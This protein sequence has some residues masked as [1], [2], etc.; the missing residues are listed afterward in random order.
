[1]SPSRL[2]VG[3]LAAALVTGSSARAIDCGTAAR[4][5]AAATTP[6]AV[7]RVAGDG[8]PRDYSVLFAGDG[9]KTTSDDGPD[10]VQSDLEKYAIAVQDLAEG[11]RN[12]RPFG[13]VQK[14]SFYRI[15]VID[16]SGD[17][18]ND[19]ENLTTDPLDEVKL[20]LSGNPLVP[21]G[22]PIACDLGSRLC[23][24]PIDRLRGNTRVLYTDQ[25]YGAL[26][27]TAF[28]PLPAG[29]IDAVVIVADTRRRA[30]AARVF[31]DAGETPVLTIGVDADKVEE[32]VYRVGQKA[33]KLLAHE[34]GHALGLLDEYSHVQGLPPGTFRECRNVWRPRS[35]PTWDPQ[36]NIGGWTATAPAIPWQS[37]LADDCDR[38]RMARCMGVRDGSRCRLDGITPERAAC[39]VVPHEPTLVCAPAEC[40]AEPG[41]WEGAFYAQTDH[42]RSEQ[43][44]LM[45]TISRESTHCRGCL[46]YLAAR[47][48]D[49]GP[50]PTTPCP[51]PEARCG[52]PLQEPPPNEPPPNQPAGAAP[53]EGSADWCRETYD[54]IEPGDCPAAGDPGSPPS[55]R[56]RVVLEPQPP[57]AQPPHPWRI[58]GVVVEVGEGQLD[59]ARPKSCRVHEALLGGRVERFEVL[60]A[61]GGPPVA[62]EAVR[63]TN[64]KHTLEIER[65]LL[66][67]GRPVLRWWL[68]ENSSKQT[69]LLYPEGSA[70]DPGEVMLAAELFNLGIEAQIV[71]TTTDTEASV[72]GI[73]YGP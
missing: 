63:I 68:T 20:E 41:A 34:L 27:L 70:V 53:D 16:A 32:G 55:P 22:T 7:V 48:C 13:D 1:M 54:L 19:C 35:D 5:P 39:A 51:P 66:E 28:A 73:E 33:V 14:F 30:G 59:P 3:L 25:T 56:W 37:R 71:E 29:E 47:L 9:F 18:G 24:H 26:A 50:A 23:W 2:T 4:A 45:K 64:G 11:L 52:E 65:R 10:G 38:T 44:C 8:D 60:P 57:A 15:D 6:P 43:Q 42:Y 58:G 36:T 62:A 17:I 46:D 69:C 40:R 61:K 12:V 72:L 21:G 31:V 67:S 49:F